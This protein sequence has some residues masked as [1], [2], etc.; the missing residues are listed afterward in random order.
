MFFVPSDLISVEN[1]LHAYP[2]LS[3]AMPQAPFV[4]STLLGTPPIAHLGNAP[5]VNEALGNG[6][7]K[8]LGW[9]TY[10]FGRHYRSLQCIL[11]L[12]YFA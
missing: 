8:Q 9:A 5:P 11:C 12:L 10:L 3:H 6:L 4:C 7:E 1:K 2:V